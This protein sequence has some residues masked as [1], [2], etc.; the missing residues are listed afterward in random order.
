MSNWIITTKSQGL[1]LFQYVIPRG[2][3]M[4]HFGVWNLI[5][6]QFKTDYIND[7]WPSQSIDEY[8]VEEEADHDD[9]ND[10]E[11]TQG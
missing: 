2:Q 1:Q 9:I 3:A 5:K 4:W 6:W 11:D 8:V 10:N 7:H